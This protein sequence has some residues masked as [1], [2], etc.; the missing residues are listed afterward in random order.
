MIYGCGKTSLALGMILTLAAGAASAQ[1]AAGD[2]ALAQSMAACGQ[3]ANMQKRV[4]CYDALNQRTQ[5]PTPQAKVETKRRDFGFSV[6]KAIK[7]P[8]LLAAPAAA[9]RLAK[10]R[11]ADPA[12]EGVNQITTRVDHTRRGPTGQLVLVTAEGSVWM[13][14]NDSPMLQPAK[15]A[16]V[17]IRRGSLGSLFCDLDR[18]R[19]IRCKRLQ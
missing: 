10:V 5:P 2:S 13:L 9:A 12:E 15:G 8:N 1:P 16:E 19:A 7:P 17:L 11:P 6:P 4:A 3:I 14:E 18:F